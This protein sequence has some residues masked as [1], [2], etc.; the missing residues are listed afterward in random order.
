MGDISPG[1][2][3]VDQVYALLGLTESNGGIALVPPE[4]V[5]RFIAM[6]PQ[7]LKYAAA[8][9]ALQ[10]ATDA[11]L[12]A[13]PQQFSLQGVMSVAFR[14]PAAHW[15]S[16]YRSMLQMAEDDYNRDRQAVNA[17]FTELTNRHQIEEVAEWSLPRRSH[18]LR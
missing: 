5:E 2:S 11:A 15:M 4:N 7:N 10:L 3:P 13:D 12:A 17:V 8:N 6:Y 9:I 18:K 14:D 1:T 16:I